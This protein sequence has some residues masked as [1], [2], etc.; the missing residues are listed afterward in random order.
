MEDIKVSII[1]PVFNTSKYLRQ[2][3]DSIINQT[4]R[5]I[6]VICVDDGSND[7]SL[8]ILKEYQQHDSRIKVLTQKHK[9]QGAARNYGISIATG[10]YI[11]F[12]D[13]DDWCESDMFEKLYKRAKETDSDITMCAVTT[14][15]DNNSNEYSKS[16]TYANLDI[17]PKEFFNKVFSPTDTLDFF[18]DICVYPPNK[19]IRRKLI[20]SNNIKFPENIDH[21]ED[22]IFSFDV[23]LSAKKISLIK[24]FGYYYRMYSDTS[25]SYTSDYG[26][27]QIFTAF[28]EKQRILKRHGVYEKVSKDFKSCKRKNIILW[29]SKITNKP[30]K[31]LYLLLTLINM[32]SCVLNS[33]SIFI[34]EMSLYARILCN[35]DQ[36]IAFWGASS[37]LENFI[38]KYHIKN[39]NIVGIIDKNPAK[40][41]KTVGGY[42]CY[43][44]EQLKELRADMVVSTIVNFSESN[45][46]SIKEFMQETGQKKIDF[47]SI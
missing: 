47:E 7:N 4:L 22:R 45:K 11:G 2:C 27:L 44:P 13:S 3:L 39:N 9:R 33:L 40:Q 38:S 18:M 26:K 32:P 21:Y 34:K 8:D 16:N 30:V 5:D 42:R 17:F 19:I 41:N 29:G 31:C 15:N 28:R 10:E 23:W 12:V 25:V 37:F 43:S 36:R 1:V 35:H 20:D 46:K 14:F 24:H 6:E